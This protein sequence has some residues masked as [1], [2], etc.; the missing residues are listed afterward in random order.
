MI[1][2]TI[3][4]LN[5]NVA[6]QSDTVQ[7]KPSVQIHE[8]VMTTWENQTQTWAIENIYSYEARTDQTTWVEHTSEIISM[9]T[10]AS[11]GWDGKWWTIWWEWGKMIITTF[12]IDFGIFASLTDT[13]TMRGNRLGNWGYLTVQDW[14][15]VP[16]GWYVMLD[17]TDM[18]SSV[19]GVIDDSSL[20]LTSYAWTQAITTLQGTPSLNVVG[21]WQWANLDGDLGYVIMERTSMADGAAGTYGILPDFALTVPAYTPLGTYQGTIEVSLYTN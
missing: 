2:F 8:Q 14:R 13:Y 7:D 10:D 15:V 1:F 6:A 21:I 16:N 17:A 20:M 12:D 19:G 3:L 9:S 4:W 11:R 5:Q 18:V